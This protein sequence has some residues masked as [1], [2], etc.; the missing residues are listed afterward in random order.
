MNTALNLRNN[1]SFTFSFTVFT[2]GRVDL[3]C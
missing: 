1:F 3:L 2:S